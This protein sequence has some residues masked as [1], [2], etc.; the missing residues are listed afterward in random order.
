MKT[1]GFYIF[2]YKEKY[3]VFY[4]HRYSYPD[5]PWGLGFRIV[6]EIRYLS[7]NKMISYM[8]NVINYLKYTYELGYESELEDNRPLKQFDSLEDTLLNVDSYDFDIQ[9]DEP[10]ID[11]H[12]QFIYIIDL[13]KN[14]LKMK[15]EQSECEFTLE[16]IPHDWFKIFMNQK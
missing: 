7:P 4:N 13:D 12:I 10:M 5:G 11:T 3:Y 6:S 16:N 15:R 14:I 8:E 2:K 9:D 1:R